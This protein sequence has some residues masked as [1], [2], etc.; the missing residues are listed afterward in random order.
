MTIRAKSFV[1]RRIVIAFVFV[2]VMHIQLTQMLRDKPATLAMITNEGSPVPTLSAIIG[3]TI[4]T[5]PFVW[6]S[7]RVLCL[8]AGWPTELTKSRTA[9]RIDLTQTMYP[10]T[11]LLL[12]HR[13]A[14]VESPTRASPAAFD[15]LLCRCDFGASNL[16]AK[17][18]HQQRRHSGRNVCF[19]DHKAEVCRYE[20][21]RSGHR[22][23]DAS[24][25]S[26]PQLLHRDDEIRDY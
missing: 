16:A 22:R 12:G 17:E 5:T 19:L 8:D 9:L 7:I 13:K 4:H 2:L 10:L 18:N 15:E 26:G 25:L 21:N 11:H 3:I 23:D 20:H 6:T 1:I 24:R 14:P